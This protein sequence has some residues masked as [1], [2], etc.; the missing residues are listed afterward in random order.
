MVG[1]SG[2]NPRDSGRGQPSVSHWDQLVR[3]LLD[4]LTHF[5]SVEGDN[6]GDSYL[7]STL[8]FYQSAIRQSATSTCKKG[9]AWSNLRRVTIEASLDDLWDDIRPTKRHEMHSL[10]HKSDFFE[11]FGGH[12]DTEIFRASFF[13]SLKPL[14]PAIGNR[15]TSNVLVHELSH[16][17]RF[18]QD[19]S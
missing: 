18:D 3:C 17:R 4:R 9:N 5:V 6:G 13:G 1:G 14:D 19:N 10:A 16:F 7:R 2:L 15:D 11:Q 12:F 8:Q